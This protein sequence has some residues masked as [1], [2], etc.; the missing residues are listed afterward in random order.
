MKKFISII[1]VGILVLSGLGAAAFTTNVSLKSAMIM[2]TEST[3]VLFSSQPIQL[4]KDGFVELEM[5][6]ATTQLLEPNKPVLPIYVRTYEIPFGSTNIQVTCSPQ[7]I[8]SMTLS[9]EVIPARIAP[10]SMMSENMAYVKDASVYGSAAFYPDNWFSYDL[11]AGRNANDQQ[12]TFVKVV[13]YPVRYSPLNNQVDY[14]GGF[15]INVNV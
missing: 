13:C 11:G 2:K 8:G 4:E 5:N 15:D 12:V 10:L 3:S 6:G 1:I 7:D 14:A 9:A